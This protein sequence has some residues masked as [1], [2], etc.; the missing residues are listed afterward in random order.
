MITV[1]KLIALLAEYCADVDEL[2]MRRSI[3]GIDVNSDNT[4]TVYTADGNSS[5]ITIEE[6]IT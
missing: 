2:L 3:F 1:G 4:I 5:D 6:G